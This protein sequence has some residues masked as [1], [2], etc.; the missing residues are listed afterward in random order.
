MDTGDAVNATAGVV[1]FLDEDHATF[2]TPTGFDVQ[3]VRRDG[4]KLLP[5]CM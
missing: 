4:P 3:L 1:T 2:A 5:M